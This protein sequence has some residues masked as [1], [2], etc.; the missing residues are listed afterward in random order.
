M[1]IAASNSRGENV[2]MIQSLTAQISRLSHSVDRWNS[3]IIVMMVA[4]ALAAT[5]LVVTQYIAVRKAQRLS[6]VQAQ[7][8]A[9][10]DAQLKTDLRAK[11]GEIAAASK[12]A[13]DANKTAGEA[14]ERAGKFEDE[15]ARLTA[16]NL[17]LEAAIAPRRL[18]DSQQKALAT[19]KGFPNRSIEIKS[20][21]SD[22]EG[23]VLAT[24]I[25][26][27]L[28]KVPALGITDNRLTMQPAGTISFGVS[29]DGKDK[30]LVDEL[31]R[32]L[33]MDG[34]LT[35]TS[36]FSAPKR[37]G[38]TVTAS[39]GRIEGPPPAATITVGVKPIK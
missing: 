23:L 22:T 37:G 27:D 35:E 7:L 39:F 38:F 30:A 19:L 29:V 9:A 14:N 5:G 34:H 18:S 28:L 32:I 12:A 4:A 13:G 16:D 20:Y 31:K 10:K 33:S 26:E 17:R 3:A 11:D 24:Q 15:A 8:D 21:S 2:D 25:L 6:A 1:T 36:S